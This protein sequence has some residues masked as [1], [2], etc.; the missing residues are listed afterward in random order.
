MA[1]FTLCGVSIGL[2][3][4]SPRGLLLT[5]LT[6]TLTAPLVYLAVRKRLDLFEP[7][8]I[9]NLALAVM[10]IARPLVDL[11]AGYP[12]HL[13][14][15]VMPTFDL[16]LALALAGAAAFQLGYLGRWGERLAPH[17]PR[18]P[19]DI[20]TDTAVA[21]T[22]LVVILGVGAYAI[23]LMQ[24]G[25]VGTLASLLSGRRP[26]QNEVFLA[27]TGYLYQGLLVSAPAALIFVGLWQ[28]ARRGVLFV[29]GL[30]AGL[31]LAISAAATGTR[32]SLLPLALAPAVFLY[33]SR[34]KR[35]R[36]AGL[37]VLAY[38]VLTLG[39][40]FLGE[41]R[42]YGS[43]A[44]RS[45]G[46]AAMQNLVH[47]FETLQ[48]TI[49]GGDADMFDSLA[50]EASI[51]PSQLPY[52]HGALIRDVFVRAIPRPLMPTKPME[53]NDRMVQW[54][55]PSHYA[56]SRASAAFSFVGA[57]YLDSGVPA[58][59]VG[60]F[61]LGATFRMLW[62]YFQ[63]SKDGICYQLM[64]SMSLP[65]TVILLRGTLQ[66]TL[67]RMLF[68]VGPLALVIF[69]AARRERLLRPPLDDGPSVGAH[70]VDR[71]GWRG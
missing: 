10:F 16:A 25:G 52:Q 3:G 4:R 21:A 67:S 19:A 14:Y 50:N 6:V 59:L 33:M 46:E 61:V 63:R 37:L 49:A 44:N 13:G 41:Y 40:G 64:Y 22:A 29:M 8:T 30:G 38:L 1:M 62:V 27:S 70:S 17:L 18:L 47:P 32:S 23:F 55:W 35:P 71:G 56:L 51:V 26:E 36:I 15:A 7:L 34:D 20:H 66:D 12:M 57:L 68:T 2:L 54:L 48:Q 24:S 58:V 69:L 53:A 9:S 28:R 60:M 45:P 31:L 65:Y 5:A 42:V 39:I 11:N 43:A